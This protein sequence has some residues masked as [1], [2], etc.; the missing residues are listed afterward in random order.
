MKMIL[1]LEAL[2]AA[3]AVGATLSR[4]VET[5]RPRTRRVAAARL[6]K[7]DGGCI[8]AWLKGEEGC[9]AVS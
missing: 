3:E 1:G 4:V 6:N 9:G 5:N 7:G 8:E 2:L